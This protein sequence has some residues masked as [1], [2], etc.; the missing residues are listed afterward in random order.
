[1]HAELGKRYLKDIKLL[2]QEL[3]MRL[4]LLKVKY[5]LLKSIEDPFSLDAEKLH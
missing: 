2:I 5:M 4:A 1:M 3:E